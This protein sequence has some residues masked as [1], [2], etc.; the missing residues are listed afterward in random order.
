MKTLSLFC[1]LIIC[2]TGLI[3]AFTSDFLAGSILLFVGAIA[4]LIIDYPTKKRNGYNAKDFM[5]R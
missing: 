5:N 2:S 3:T 4:F 1:C